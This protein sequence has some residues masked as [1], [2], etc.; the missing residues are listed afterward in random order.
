MSIKTILK[1]VL[2][3]SLTVSGGFNCSKD[4][5]A[6]CAPSSVTATIQMSKTS[7]SCGDIDLPWEITFGASF[8]FTIDIECTG[9]CS[10]KRVLYRQARSYLKK[11]GGIVEF[12]G[13][14]SGGACNELRQPSQVLN[15]RKEGDPGLI[16]YE[17]G[18]TVVY[19][20]L[21]PVLC[22]SDGFSGCAS[23]EIPLDIQEYTFE[24][25]L[26]PEDFECN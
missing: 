19:A 26:A 11:P 24:Y 8:E 14:P 9:D 13:V 18:D 23:E 7:A 15:T 3:L 17:I 20:F 10:G 1:A 16:T 4:K 25:V 22:T 21:G 5:K 12:A 2:L 6:E